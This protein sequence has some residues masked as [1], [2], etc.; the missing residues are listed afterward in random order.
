MIELNYQLGSV[1]NAN[2][3]E[4][5]EISSEMEKAKIRSHYEEENLIGADRR[6]SSVVSD[7]T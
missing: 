2:F 3:C 4:E 7:P 6:V 1:Q 5:D